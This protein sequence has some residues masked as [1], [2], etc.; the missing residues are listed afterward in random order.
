M[1]V[2]VTGAR[3]II[4][5]HAIAPLLRLGVDVHLVSRRPMPATT[6]VTCHT[7]DLLDWR[8]VD[9]LLRTVAPS[10]LLHLAWYT[11]HGRFWTAP[12]N[13][14]WVGA[15][16]H[17]VNRFVEHGGVRATFAGSCAEYSWTDIAPLSEFASPRRPSTLYGITKNALHEVVHGFAAQTGLSYAWGRVFFVHGPGE[18][19]NR[20]VPSIV[21]SVVAG[22]IARCSHGRQVRDFLSTVE[23][24]EA[25]VAL[26]MSPVQGPVNVASGIPVTI[27]DVARRTAQ[28]AGNAGRL[29]LGT[30]AAAPDDPP[31]IV[32]D[33][34]R[35]RTEVGW[36]PT[37]TLDEALADTVASWR[38]R[39]PGTEEN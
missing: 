28:L 24:A 34:T 2:V 31:V 23:A 1:R 17:L 30:I 6:G 38:T 27:A 20:L 3:G 10:H 11:E 14:D 25:F 15:S 12:E 33:I 7:G 37:R 19:P 21:R 39:V 5:R 8:F 4:G 16:L 26:L 18:P 32:A 9:Q 22:E 29:A 35:L 36:A 13:L